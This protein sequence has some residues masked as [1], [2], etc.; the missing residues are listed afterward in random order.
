MV[1]LSDLKAF[2]SFP[3]QIRCKNGGGLSLAV[4][5]NML[6]DAI[7]EYGVP[8]D[9]REDQVQSGGLF[10][11]KYEECLCIV[12]SEHE[13]DYF[14]YCIR[15]QK[16]GTMAFVYV[17]YFGTSVLTGKKNQD[18]DRKNSGSLAKMA[19]GAIFKVDQQA[20]DAEYNYYTIIEDALKEVLGV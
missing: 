20:Y 3:E 9:I 13:A 5:K 11:K 12:N 17:N 7:S 4:L 1:Y 18:E 2:D 19:L 14:K 16:T 15:L 6:H 8:F 10:N